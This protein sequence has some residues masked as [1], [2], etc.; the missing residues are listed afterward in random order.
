MASDREFVVTLDGAEVE[1]KAA[2]LDEAVDLAILMA[3][4]AFYRVLDSSARM[5]VVEK[6]ANE[7]MVVEERFHGVDW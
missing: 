2:D 5:A 7:R 4:W 3:G 1:L 6:R